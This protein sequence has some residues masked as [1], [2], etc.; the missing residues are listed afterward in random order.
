MWL[1]MVVWLPLFAVLC[2]LLLRPV[3][4]G[5]VGYMTRM[6]FLDEEPNAAEGGKRRWRFRAAV[7]EDGRG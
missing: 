3:K 4:G 5:V 2:T 7:K 1:H 6:G